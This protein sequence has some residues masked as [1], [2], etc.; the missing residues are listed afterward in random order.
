MSDHRSTIITVAPRD[1]VCTWK[2]GERYVV[3]HVDGASVTIQ[4]DDGYTR[5]VHIDHLRKYFY[6]TPRE[7]A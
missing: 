7:V 3:T 4:S 6:L 2:F 5:H 1:V